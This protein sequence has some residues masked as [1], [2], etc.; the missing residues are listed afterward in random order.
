MWLGASI[1]DNS[2]DVVAVRKQPEVRCSNKAGRHYPSNQGFEL[3]HE[4]EGS[5]KRILGRE[6]LFLFLKIWGS[7][8]I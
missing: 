3:Y 7:Q 8:R 5:H 4:G 1:L 6:V 2:V